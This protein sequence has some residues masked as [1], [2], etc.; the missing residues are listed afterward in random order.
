M[1]SHYYGIRNFID[2]QYSETN[3]D[4]LK[5]ILDY[6]AEEILLGEIFFDNIPD[7]MRSKYLEPYENDYSKLA[8][9][10]NDQLENENITNFKVL[11]NLLRYTDLIN[12]VSNLPEVKNYYFGN[13]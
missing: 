10:M 13:L 9:I 11:E 7:S 8:K 3:N 6:N 5:E 12:F 1:I 2:K 4:L